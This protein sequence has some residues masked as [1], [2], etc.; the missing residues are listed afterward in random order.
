M[1]AVSKGLS[2]DCGCHVSTPFL[3]TLC[4]GAVLAMP[5]S[6]PSM[7]RNQATE[8]K[9]QKEGVGTAPVQAAAEGRAAPGSRQMGARSGRQGQTEGSRDIIPAAAASSGCMGLVRS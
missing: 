8:E 3:W 4:R 7:D 1:A 2:S 5:T 6:D 9:A